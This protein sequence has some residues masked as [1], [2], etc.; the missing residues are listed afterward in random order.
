MGDTSLSP[1]SRSSSSLADILVWFRE[2]QAEDVD[3]D[4]VEIPRTWISS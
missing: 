3:V 4:L 1:I 2:I